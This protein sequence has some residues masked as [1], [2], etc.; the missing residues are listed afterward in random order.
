M[1]AWIVSPILGAALIALVISSAEA[2]EMPSHRVAVSR[3]VGAGG[4]VSTHRGSARFGR[5]I[6]FGSVDD[7]GGF[8]DFRS[9][10]PASEAPPGLDFIEPQPTPSKSAAELPPCHEMT[11]VGIVIE[12]G[13]AA[14]ASEP[15]INRGPKTRF[16][17][18]LAIAA[19]FFLC[20]IS[21]R[22][23][24]DAMRHLNALTTPI[25]SATP[26]RANV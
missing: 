6:S 19:E 22:A 18:H 12:R 26:R 9:P 20:G 24:A 4:A 14:R 3:H 8:D 10:A 23:R 2:R 16:H 17:Q 21:V 7:L 1:R 13:T 25:S 15:Q 11:P 5:S